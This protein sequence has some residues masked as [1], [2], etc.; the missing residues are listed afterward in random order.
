MTPAPRRS[1]GH[2]LHDITYSEIQQQ[3][4]GEQIDQ[5][6]AELHG[7]VTGWVCAGAQWDQR[8]RLNALHEHYGANVSDAFQDILNRLHASIVSGLRDEGL[9][10]RLLLPAD[11]LPVNARTRAVSDWCGGFLAGFGMTGRYRDDELAGELREVFQDLARI[12]AISEDVPDDDDNEV[13][14]TEIIEY[15]R[16]AALMVFTECAHHAV[17]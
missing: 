2:K 14:L 16:M 8:E 10:F 11:D 1:G 12:A 6:A 9:G 17:H 15:V 4:A 5:P 3:L 7:L 13:D